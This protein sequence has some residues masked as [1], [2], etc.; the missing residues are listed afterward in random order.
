[1]MTEFKGAWM[2]VAALSVSLMSG[3]Q[4]TNP[5]PTAVVDTSCL[6]FE[7]GLKDNPEAPRQWRR[8]MAGHKAAYE[9]LCP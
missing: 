6:V 2:L 3:C 1:M 4:T 7:P 5:T 9:T 8:W